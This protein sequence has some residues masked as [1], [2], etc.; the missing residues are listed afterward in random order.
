MKPSGDFFVEIHEFGKLPKE[1]SV[2]VLRV[3]R[4]NGI[5]KGVSFI[6]PCGEH[7]IYIPLGEDN[8]EG[9]SE[10]ERQLIWTLPDKILSITPSIKV[11]GGCNLHFYITLNKFVF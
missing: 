5:D 3:A 10:E 8:N 11:N 4:E 1:M 2:E 6:C 7:Q 9:G